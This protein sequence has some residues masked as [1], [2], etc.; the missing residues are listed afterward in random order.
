MKNKF[1][2]GLLIST[3]IFGA[4]LSQSFPAGK[5]CLYQL[6][7]KGKPI[8]V[9]V[10][11]YVASSNADRVIIEY[12]LSSREGLLPV[13]MWQQFEIA[14]STSGSKINKGFV[15]TK[16]LKNPETLTEEYLKGLD[17]VQ[18]NDFVFSTESQL[19]KNKIGEETVEEPAGKDKAMHYRTISGENTIDYWISESARPIGLVK[20]VSKHPTEEKKNYQLVLTSLMKNVKPYIDPAKAVPLTSLGKSFLAKPESVR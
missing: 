15:Q 2:L 7:V 6:E 9:D 19:N 8:P 1:F 14:P 11:I 3:N 10:S 5:G 16:E 4:D 12:F 17:G 13:E 20:L 18:V